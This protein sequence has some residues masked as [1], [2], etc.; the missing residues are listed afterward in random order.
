MGLS[1]LDLAVRWP[2]SSIGRVTRLKGIPVFGQ[3]QYLKTPGGWVWVMGSGNKILAKFRVRAIEGPK[4]VELA[5]GQIRTGYMLT[6]QPKSFSLAEGEDSP[7]V[8]GRWFA[9]GQFKY[10]SKSA[11]H[12]VVFDNTRRSSGNSEDIDEGPEDSRV[13]RFH[14]RP[15][16]GGIPGKSPGHPESKLVAA[17][18][19]W[20]RAPHRFIHPFLPM[21]RHFADLFD[22]RHWR[23]FEAKA[24]IDRSVVREAVGQLFD[25]KREFARA[26]SI[27]ILLPERPSISVI[28]YLDHYKICA[29]WRTASGRF[30]DS[31]NGLYCKRASV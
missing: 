30:N 20:T 12:L 10:F 9:Q 22:Q 21:D 8:F 1:D 11:G 19:E 23:L 29:V 25:Y 7:I 15:Y 31:R 24:N 28:R 26:P 3:P 4:T 14:A 27:A 6:S 13:E 5:E 18:V 17:Y 2:D 16:S